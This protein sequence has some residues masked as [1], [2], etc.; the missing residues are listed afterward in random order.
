MGGAGLV[1]A[2]GYELVSMLPDLAARSA[3]STNSLA[4]HLSLAPFGAAQ[5]KN[6]HYVS[7]AVFAGVQSGIL[8]AAGMAPTDGQRRVAMGAFF[9]SWMYGA[10]DGY[11][12]HAE[13]TS[14]RSSALQI[15]PVVI[16]DHIGLAVS[17]RY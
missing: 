10:Y 4:K 5:A 12:N 1:G 16:E 11:K 6:G 15:L 13:G 14:T 9:V 17:F 2:Y 3:G 7:A 8:L